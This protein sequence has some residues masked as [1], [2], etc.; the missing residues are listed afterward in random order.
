VS[1]GVRIQNFGEG[2]NDSTPMAQSRHH[3]S[4]KRAVDDMRS[5][6]NEMKLLSCCKF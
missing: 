5:A 1:S 3:G 6:M 4:K 2:R